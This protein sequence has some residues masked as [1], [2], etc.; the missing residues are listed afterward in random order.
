[1]KTTGPTSLCFENKQLEGHGK[2]IIIMVLAR[3]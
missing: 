3:Q 2:T 1:M